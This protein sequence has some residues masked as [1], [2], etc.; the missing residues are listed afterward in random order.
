LFVELIATVLSGIGIYFLL[1][2]PKEKT[3]ENNFIDK[4]KMNNNKPKVGG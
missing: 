4:K 2:P 1:K 3:D